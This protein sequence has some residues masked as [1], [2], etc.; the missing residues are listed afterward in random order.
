MDNSGPAFPCAAQIYSEDWSA[1]VTTEG[2]LTKRELA[3]M[4]ALQGMA[5]GPYW[6]ENFVASKPDF[7]ESVAHTAVLAADALLAELSKAD[8]NG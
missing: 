3:A 6:C 1:R 5:A 8:G 4:L 7:L 2:G